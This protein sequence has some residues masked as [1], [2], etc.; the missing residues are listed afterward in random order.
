MEKNVAPF[1]YD[2]KNRRNQ[3]WELMRGREKIEER[4][5]KKR[6]EKWVAKAYWSYITIMFYNKKKPLH[7][8]FQ[9]L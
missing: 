1:V 4:K 9:W 8:E 6:K 2:G 5:E 7:K 3:V